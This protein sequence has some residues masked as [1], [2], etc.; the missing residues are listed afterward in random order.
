MEEASSPN[1][2]HHSRE[3]PIYN[4]PCRRNDLINLNLCTGEHIIKVKREFW[5]F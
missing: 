5:S 2:D 4:N 1:S 3:M